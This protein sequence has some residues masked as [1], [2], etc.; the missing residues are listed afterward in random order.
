M[1]GYSGPLG[2]GPASNASSTAPLL[3][4]QPLQLARETVERI[5]TLGTVLL[6]ASVYQFW[7][8]SSRQTTDSSA[9]AVLGEFSNMPEF[10]I[11][12]DESGEPQFQ[13]AAA[14]LT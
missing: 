3:N 8:R 11:G 7:L 4:P 1:R 6:L 13:L 14:A 10:A 12:C 5:Q 9:A 2:S